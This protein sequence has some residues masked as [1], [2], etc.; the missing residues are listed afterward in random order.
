VNFDPRTTLRRD[1]LADLRL[2]GLIE[3]ERFDATRPMQAAMPSAAIRDA[4]DPAAQQVDQ[5]LFGEGFE[6][7]ET[8]DGFHFG[9][10]RRDGYVGWVSADALVEAGAPP[11]H[12]IGVRATFAFAA[13]SIKAPVSEPIG[14]N[15]LVAA[16][17]ES[18][19]FVRTACLGWLPKRHLIPIGEVRQDPAAV[20]LEHLHAPYLWGGRHASGLDCSGLVQQAR[21]ACGLGCPRDTDQQQAL[22]A[23]TPP[24]GLRR[25]DLV[26][27]KGHVAM[28][29]DAEVMV[30]ANAFHMGVAIEPLAEAIQRID[31]AGGGTPTAFRRP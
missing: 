22:G 21:L 24:D 3:A 28:M 4:P 18:G 8:R 17:D 1:G 11:T 2:E 5:L 16:T 27:W 25:G 9:Q 26:F 13:A 12:W 31:A 14:L 30:H 20:A 29:I 10:A 19:P 15:S 6:V 23:E 7:L